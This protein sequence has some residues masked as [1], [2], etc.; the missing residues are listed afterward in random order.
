MHCSMLAMTG[1]SSSYMISMMFWVFG[2]YSYSGFPA[3][4]WHEDPFFDKKYH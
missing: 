2:C 3:I 1:I 4:L